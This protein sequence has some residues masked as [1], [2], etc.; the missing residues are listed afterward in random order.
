MPPPWR[1]PKT[2]GASQSTGN[3]FDVQVEMQVERRLAYDGHPYTYADVLEHYGDVAQ[4]F[5]LAALLALVEPTLERPYRQH[6]SRA[7][8]PGDQRASA[9]FAVPGRSAPQPTPWPMPTALGASQFEGNTFDGPC[10]HLC[11]QYAFVAFN[12]G[13]QQNMLDENGNRWKEHSKQLAKIF[14]KFADCG[15]DFIFGCELGGLQE[16][17]KHANINMD[18]IVHSVLPRAECETSG[19]YFAVHNCLPLDDASVTRV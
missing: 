3:K 19:A 5:W 9:G 1:T 17:V 13:V 6:L 14:E 11:V 2:F 4:S 10:N 18:K 8:Q 16:G 12:F 15:A 7:P